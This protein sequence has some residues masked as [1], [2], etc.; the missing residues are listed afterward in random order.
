M[1]CGIESAVGA[2][3]DTGVERLRVGALSANDGISTKPG[4]DLSVDRHR[5]ELSDAVTLFG[6]REPWFRLLKTDLRPDFTWEFS[7]HSLE[8]P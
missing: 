7:C 3:R 4:R 8:A 5:P 2:P 6:A 1:L